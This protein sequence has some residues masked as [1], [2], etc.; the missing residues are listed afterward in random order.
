MNKQ[1]P[2]QPPKKSKF[3]NNPINKEESTNENEN[4]D[5]FS[6]DFNNDLP[7][8]PVINVDDDDVNTEKNN[9]YIDSDDYSLSESDNPYSGKVDSVADSDSIDDD[10]DTSVFNA[11]SIDSDSDVDDDKYIGYEEDHY[12]NDDDGNDDDDGVSDVGHSHVDDPIDD[13][14]YY[15]ETEDKRRFGKPVLIILSIVLIAAVVGVWFF[16]FA[17]KAMSIEV[18][19]AKQYVSYND[20]TELCED[21]SQLTCNQEWVFSDKPNGTLI[22][23]SLAPGTM[24]SEG[25]PISLTYSKGVE[26]PVIPESIIGLN[27]I[28]ARETLYSLGLNVSQIVRVDDSGQPA[29]TVVSVDPDSV[30]QSVPNG[31]S[32]SLYV[33]TG[34]IVVPDWTGKTKEFVQA[35]AENMN[36][37]VVFTD[38]ESDS[39]VGT[40][41]SQSVINEEINEGDAV[42]IVVAKGFSEEQVAIPD[43][44]GMSEE[45]A[46]SILAAEG[47]RQIVTVNVK[48]NEVT[49]KQVTQVTPS[50]GN[51]VGITEKVLIVVSEPIEDEVDTPEQAE[52]NNNA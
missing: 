52:S 11:T 14:V 27:E 4:N 22:S 31:S 5:G 45:E 20:T 12:T 38:E 9:D 51:E 37:S 17:P 16:F 47:F 24:V 29:N 44:L 3:T 23:Q 42:E 7:Q 28:D 48:N 50:V 2:F 46:Q 18:S 35:E 32:I 10:T 19:Q 25:T 21:F 39:P 6:L 15:D 41:I 8:E 33:A 49:S 30:G 40:I 1:S 36:I 13:E 34:S 26:N 43:V